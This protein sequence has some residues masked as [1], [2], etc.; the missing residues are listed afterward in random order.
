MLY[1]LTRMGQRLFEDM[2][3][4]LAV[5]V[6]GPGI[7]AFGDGPDGG[8]EA[9]FEGRLHYPEPA[10]DEQWN[11]FGVLQVK[12]RRAGI[13]E[14]DLDWL[15]REIT[16]ELAAWSSPDKKRITEG[17]MPE[18]L[19][20]ATNVR[21]TSA[22]RVGGIDRIRTFMAGHAEK[23]GLKGWALWDANQLTMYLN[24]YP[25]VSTKFA[26]T[27]T[28][29]DVIAKLHARIDDLGRSPTP[30]QIRVGQGQ[31]GNE[32][33]FLAAYQAGGGRAVLGAPTS[34]V[35]EDGPGWVQ[36]LT[37]GSGRGPA[38]ICARHGGAAIAVDATV[39]DAICG[40][41]ADAGRLDAVGYP[42][43]T[44]HTEAF[45]N[46]DVEEVLLSGGRWGPG[47]LVRQSTGACCW[48]AQIG[49][50]FN[51]RERDR[52]TA[53]ANKMDLRVRCAAR[54]E[55]PTDDLAVGGNRRQLV[56]NL[57]NSPVREVV[58]KVAHRLGL[59]AEAALWERT[60]AAEGHNDRR[61][62]SYRLQ[63]AGEGD[64]TALGLW[65]W[66]QLPDGLQSTVI[67]MVDMRVDFTAL[68]IDSNK[69]G[70]LIDPAHQ[71]TTEQLI[72]FFTGAWATATNVLPTALTSDPHLIKP[73]GPTTIE[74]HIINERPPA[75]GGERTLGLLDMVDLTPLGDPPSQIGAQMS[76]AVT[77][78]LQLDRQR[79][80]ELVTETLAYMGS[81]YG[82]LE[83]DEP[84]AE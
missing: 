55:W 15:R 73:A 46:A 65:V 40:A 76:T 41:G 6:L 69:Q 18:Y 42:V 45:V 9:S 64:R 28:S 16:K 81:G 63:V 12:Y 61:F 56:A 29:G 2:C 68:P 51:T 49:F 32:R 22:V 26:D 47:R 59:N 8:R 62:A 82:F 79:I 58:V 33:P 10:V 60:P 75:L 43:V 83:P 53:G 57:T 20:I 24:A 80:G 34:E 77:A 67:S 7:Q 17:R 1:D 35:Y 50:S 44:P 19:I 21:L 48:E 72:D 14:K 3:R 66:F 54:I 78:P 4:A 25:S 37:G 84:T 39:W 27:I 71:M 13:G 38:V 23:L 31:A 74:L 5:H 52:W 70:T 36:H 30:D 11:G